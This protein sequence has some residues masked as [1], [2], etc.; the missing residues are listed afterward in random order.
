MK[1]A[2]APWEGAPRLL[3]PWTRRLMLSPRHSSPKSPR[4]LQ[5]SG[6]AAGSSSLTRGELDSG[7]ECHHLFS[8]EAL[9]LTL[10]LLT[11]LYNPQPVLARRALKKNVLAGCAGTCGNGRTRGGVGSRAR[12]LGGPQASGVGAAAT[13]SMTATA[14]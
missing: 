14:H 2:A 12:Q 5:S 13:D 7:M 4:R 8:R 1:G 10:K 11:T 6:C 3:D 9:A